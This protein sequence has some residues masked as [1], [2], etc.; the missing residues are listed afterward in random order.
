MEVKVGTEYTNK[1]GDKVIIKHIKNVNEITIYFKEYDFTKQC[2]ERDL[3]GS[4]CPY[5]K[6]VYGVGYLGLDFYRYKGIGK[7]KPYERWRNMLKR[8]YFKCKK[9][10]CYET[11]DVCKEWH[12]F[13]VFYKWYMKNYYEIKDTTM[14]L[15]K[16]IKVKNSFIYS[17]ETCIFIPQS[18]NQIF[19]G[20]KREKCEKRNDLPLGVFWIEADKIYGCNCRTCDGKHEW[21]GRSM[22]IEELF[23]RYVKRKKQVIKDE[24]EKYKDDIPKEI[25]DIILSYE[26][27]IND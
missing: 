7:F 5:S 3:L 18:I 24:V 10:K 22:D 21:L 12:N 9:H 4:K 27:D 16:D 11:I 6:S 23:D 13:S 8:C 15:D 19:E 14:T 26:F 25:I 1:Y 2:R 17:P 20:C